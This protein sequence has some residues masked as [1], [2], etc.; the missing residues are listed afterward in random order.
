MF[1]L[2]YY[3]NNAILYLFNVIILDYPFISISFTKK[4]M[5]KL[6]LMKCKIILF[7]LYENNLNKF[8]PFKIS[9]FIL[10]LFFFTILMC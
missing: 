8:F 6:L 2:L 4:Y 10:F 1:I 9:H 7:Y 5:L 3:N